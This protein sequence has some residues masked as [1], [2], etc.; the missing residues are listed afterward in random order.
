M[1][2]GMFCL[3]NLAALRHFVCEACTVRAVVNRE[4]SKRPTDLVLLMLE[5]A[6]LVDTTN[7][8]STGTIKTYQSKYRILQEFERTFELSVLHPTRLLSPLHGAAICLMWAQ[9]RYS[10]YPAEWRKKHRLTDEVVKY[11]T[12]RALRLAAAHFWVWDLLH[13]RPNRLTLGFRDKPTVVSGCSPTDEV[14]YTY[15]A[16][17]MRRRMGDHP[18]PSMVFLLSHAIWVSRYFESLFAQAVTLERQLELARAIVTHIAALLG[19][20]RVCETFGLQWQDVTVVPPIAGPTMGL[21]AG[22]GCVL[23]ALL[24]RFGFGIPHLFGSRARSLARTPQGSHPCTFT[25]P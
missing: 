2:R 22:I 16:D 11:G 3:P 20:L 25:H 14:A 23:L 13:T 8:W 18:K 4:L 7:H 21:P 19:W 12:V 10:L 17:G 6:R 15:F 5:R 1:N 9:E 24:A